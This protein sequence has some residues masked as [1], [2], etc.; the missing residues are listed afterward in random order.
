MLGPR[1]EIN[2][3]LLTIVEQSI[4]CRSKG[5]KCLLVVRYSTAEPSIF[6]EV[7]EMIASKVTEGA[8]GG[9]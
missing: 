6:V 3:V 1:S 5:V 2:A 8:W 9:R 4:V 7:K